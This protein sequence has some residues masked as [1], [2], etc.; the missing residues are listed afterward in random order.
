LGIFFQDN[1]LADR[2]ASIAALM[3][4]FVALIPTIR[5]QIPP[6]PR[7]VFIEILVY[8]ET[9]TSLFALIH[10]LDVRK[11]EGFDLVW[12]ESGLFM[13]SLIITLLTIL[14]VLAMMVLHY[15]V[16]EPS[17]NK[18]IDDE[19]DANFKREEWKNEKCNSYFSYIKRR[20]GNILE[21]LADPPMDKEKK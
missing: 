16:W 1:N 8:F 11:I 15:F 19:T 20:G 10:S 12:Y 6:N 21:E 5:D 3:I 14:I 17:Y 18:N 13:V 7:I 4:A 2:I 9:L